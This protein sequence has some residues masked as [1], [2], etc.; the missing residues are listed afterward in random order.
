MTFGDIVSILE[1]GGHLK[2]IRW[3]YNS[4]VGHN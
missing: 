1:R 4:L 3:E 2:N